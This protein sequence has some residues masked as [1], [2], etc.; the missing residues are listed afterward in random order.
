MK[1]VLNEEIK[2]SLLLMGLPTSISNK[3]TEGF[4]PDFRKSYS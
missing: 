1:E 4:Y 2:R 3:L